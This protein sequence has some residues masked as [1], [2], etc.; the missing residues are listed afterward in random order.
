MPEVPRVILLIETSDHYGRKLLQGIARYANVHG[1]WQFYREPPFYEDVRGLKKAEAGFAEWGPNGIIAREPQ[2]YEYILHMGVPTI[3]SPNA[4]GDFP[5]ILTDHEM[6]GKMAAD[7]LLERGFSNY[8][9]CGI[10]D[11]AWSQN[12]GNSFEQ[13]V[14]KA[15][16]DTHVYEQSQD[17][18]MRTWGNEQPLLA[19]WLK[20]LPKPVGIMCCNDLRG[21]NVIDTCAIAELRV[22]EEVAVIGV[23]NDELICSLTHPPLSSVILNPENAGYQAAELLDGLMRGQDPANQI[24]LNSPVGVMTRQ[25][26]DSE[27]IEDRDVAEALHF[28]RMHAMQPIQVSDVANELCM[29]RRHLYRKFDKALGRSIHDE[30]RR[31]RIDQ[32]KRMLTETDL[33]VSQIATKMGF[34]N[35]THVSRF[36]R[37]EAQISPQ[38]FRKQYGR[39]KDTV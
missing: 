31:T 27:A 8:A 9:F 18:K 6:I 35:I 36:F 33:S 23:D 25:S 13:Q 14:A 1:P 12:R 17:L 37:Q 10:H 11:M 20:S 16:F 3:V 39:P 24:I 29:S 15:G 5:A 19:Q 7:H 28:I 34:S 38:A 22:P 32:L 30:I 26:S 4:I 21:Q 2:R